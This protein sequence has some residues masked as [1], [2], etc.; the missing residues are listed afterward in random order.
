MTF[1]D[2][3]DNSGTIAALIALAGVGLTAYLSGKAAIKAKDIPVPEDRKGR[4]KRFVSVYGRAMVSGAATCA[5]IVASD[6][7]HH[8]KEV[9]L[10]SVAASA[11]AISD[12]YVRFE[13]RAREEMGDEKTAEIHKAVREEQKG[14][15]TDNRILVYEP[16]TDQYIWTTRERIAWTMLQANRE[17]VTKFDVRLAYII[18]KLGGK[19]DTPK[20]KVKAEEIGWN[21]E[22][23]VQSDQW[24]Y[25]GGPWIDIDVELRN[26]GPRECL[27]LF[28][29]V[30]PETQR[31]EDMIYSEI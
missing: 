11:L 20:R 12:D 28:Y 24:G 21:W 30:E 27:W 7:L 1:D 14:L 8:S 23:E 2:V 31:P 6:R 15:L 22:N 5:A 3:K 17:L 4:I 26:D 29:R 18:T 19:L 13:R 25:Y 10:G 9:A 16:Y